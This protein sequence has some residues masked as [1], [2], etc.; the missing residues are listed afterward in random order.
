MRSIIILFLILVAFSARSQITST[1]DIDT[2]GW[3][4]LDGGVPISVTHIAGNG[5]PGGYI[6][7][8]YSSSTGASSESWFAPSKFLGS[9][10]V[11]S[12]GMSLRFDLQQS[13]T[14]TNS[15]F[16]GDVRI[17]SGSLYLAYSLPEKPAMSPNWSTYSLKLDE[18]QGWRI[19]TT[20]GAFATRTQIIQALSNITSIEIRGTYL[21]NTAY[22]SGLD[23]VVLE[24]RLL[25]I[26]PSVSMLSVPTGQAGVSIMIN[27]SGFGSSI[28]QNEVYFGRMG[29]TITA[30]STTQLTV[31]I[32]TGATHDKITVIN[33]ATGL[34]KQSEQLFTPTFKGGGRIIPAT[35][36]LKSDILLDPTTGNDIFG[37][38]VADLD[39]DGWNDVL[40]S[41]RIINSISIFRNLGTGG[42]LSASSFAP[43]FSVAGAGN[44]PGLRIADVDGDGKLDILAC[45]EDG[46]MRFAT[47]RNISTPGNLAFEPVELWAGLVYSGGLSTFVDVDGDGRLDLIGHHT[48]GSGAPDFWIAQNISTSG[49][50]EFGGSK[51]YFTNT[52][53]AGTGVTTGDLDADGKPEII[54]S[55]GFGASFSILKNNSTP[56]LISLTNL[57]PISTGQ[58]NRALQ[59]VDLN[60]D[61]KNDIIFK[62]NGTQDIRIRLNTNS[63]GSLA[64]S[65]F[66]SEIFLAS[67]LGNYGGM[68][69]ADVNGDGKVDILASDDGTIGIFEN[70]YTGGVFDANAFIPAYQFAGT[71]SSTYPT[72]PIAADFNG[73]AKPDIVVGITNSN[74][75]RLSFYE[76]KNVHAPAI[77][78]NTV[79]PLKGTIG[80]TVTITGTNFSTVPSENMVWFG[81]VKATVLT[82]SENL[83]TVKVPAGATYAPVSVTKNG[84]TSRYHLPFK[85]TFGLG[86]TFDNT[87]FAPPINYTLT[88]ATYN[89]EAGDLNNDGTV[90]IF[91]SAGNVAYAFR[92][93]YITGSITT[94]TLIP[95]DTLLPLNA[96]FGNPRLEDFDGDGYLDVAS[97]NTR[98]RRNITTSLDINFTPNITFAGQGNLAYA[99][100]NQDG[101]IDMAISNSGAAQLL[102]IENRTTP[103]DFINTGAF[104]S[105]SSTFAIGK[106]GVGGDVI[107]ADFDADGFP[108]V[109]TIN[110]TTDNISIFRNTGGKRI[111][112]T[113][114]GSRIDLS[115]GDNP[116]RTYKGDFDGDGKLDLMLYHGAGT[117]TTLVIV[118]HNTSTVGNI[119]FNRIDL[120]NP[121]ATTVATVADL[122]GDGKPEIITTSEAGNRFSIFKNIHTTGPLTAASFAAPFNTTVTAPRGITTAD[123]NLDGKPEIILTRAA[124]LLVVYEN[125]IPSTSITITQQP[126]DPYYV[127]EGSTATLSTDASGTTNI[128][129]QWQKLNSFTSLFE[130]LFNNST[131]SG[132]S[133][134]SLAIASITSAEGGDYQCLIRGDLAADVTTTIAS[135]VFNNL[136]APPDVVDGVS[137]GPGSVTLT[138]S[139]A[140]DGNYRWYTQAPVS[141]I[142]AEVN[143]FY[144]TPLLSSTTT[145]L[146]S[147]V[148]TFCE[149]VKVQVTAT[150]STPPA[151]PVISSSITPVGNSVTVCSSSSL[152]LSAPTGF[153]SYLWSEGSSTQQIS[154]GSSGLYSV[155]VA[156]AFGCSSPPSSNINVIVLPA[157]C[158]NQPPVISM[159]TLTTVIGGQVSINLLDFISDA[160]DNLVLSSLSISSPPASGAQATLNNNIL[161]LNYSS[162]SFTGTDV[163][164]ITVC[165]V[166]SA[167]VEQQIEIKVIGELE[168][169]N[170][171]SPNNDNLNDIFT[172]GYIDLLPDTQANKVTI[173]NRWGTKVFEVENYNND[174]RVFKGLNLNGGELPSGTYF[175]KVEFK[176]GKSPFSGYLVLKR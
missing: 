162:I 61:G 101:K 108:D 24:Q 66:D 96:L 115:V 151:A 72:S 67:D 51:S 17:E 121:S 125:L 48:A 23:N 40:V 106:P 19:N 132:V 22:T 128:T 64:L 167:C 172:I 74:P 20:S 68:S 113:Q 30:A 25:A 42:Q 168:I 28:S 164:S 58:Y 76:N 89:I 135:V 31:T 75:V 34:L 80:S 174:D 158:N 47:F 156:N 111:S 126:T 59:I 103:G 116:N 127:C 175:Y 165:D 147:I 69:L 141:A 100:F 139:G 14:G 49:D 154:V 45:Y 18:S 83:L 7:A 130:N 41:E 107:A 138:V 105:F 131:Y 112:A 98:I 155:I 170:A 13:H 33:K 97:I 163:L 144:I 1:F 176:N 91:A 71:G 11:Q 120:T 73:D 90:D 152:T 21:S 161:E 6:S 88:G 99:D 157:P 148:D 37:L 85:T 26:A 70:V 118:L 140:S 81:M 65:D 117:S 16:Y 29:A 93:D 82:A 44:Q 53:D 38:G 149:S 63:G 92:N 52:L 104:G 54:V 60:L 57:G 78:V 114:L 136:P 146:V 50:I 43:K 145:Y 134:K 153:S 166:F 39:G 86:V 36:S 129:Y 55:H 62:F 119:S 15:S 160:D 102:L 133:T 8:T 46:L 94:S 10:V 109:V 84:L 95:N 79:S 32:P 173:Y 150:I 27:G 87:H 122:D 137:C 110:S 77:S 159:P 56:G 124:G 5:N 4:F 9:Q 2:D 123:L 169:Y 12:L 35:L 3:T 171:V 142:S 143:S